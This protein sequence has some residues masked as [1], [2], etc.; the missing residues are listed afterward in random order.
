[1]LLGMVDRGLEKF[2]DA[3]YHNRPKIDLPNIPAVGESMDDTAGAPML[4]PNDHL[5]ASG[6]VAFRSRDRAKADAARAESVKGGL[7]GPESLMAQPA[8]LVAQRDALNTQLRDLR[9]ER[10]SADG[11]FVRFSKAGR[12]R[13]ATLDRAISDTRS[14]RDEVEAEIEAMLPAEK[15]V[16]TH[17]ERVR[18]A[19]ERIGEVLAVIAPRKEE[20]H[21]TR[22][23]TPRE[24]L[25]ADREALS[26]ELST[27]R[28]WQFMRKQE[29]VQDM[30]RIDLE[31]S[32]IINAERS[33]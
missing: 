33:K 20:G 17:A 21:R 32:R 23:A 13:L 8:I 12:D 10:K 24:Q 22:E 6:E 3:D 4:P 28:F 5:G 14:Q 31:M 15:Q 25:R 9:L 19:R 26:V 27:L 30:K 16:T 11:L 7:R 2:P 1:M 29:I 18:T